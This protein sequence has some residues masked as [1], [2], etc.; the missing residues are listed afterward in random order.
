MTI[1]WETMITA[2]AKAATALAAARSHA[3][4]R[5]IAHVT[6]AREALITRLPG[7][8]MIYLAKEAEARAWIAAT[9]P[10]I[11]DY[12][13]LAAEAG[14]TAPDP[15]QLAQLWLNMA[16]LWRTTAADLEAA[17]LGTEAAIGAAATAA[18][19]ERAL[20]WMSAQPDL[21]PRNGGRNMA[22]GW[23]A[24]Q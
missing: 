22:G 4:A 16:A 9:D 2:E 7:Q 1:Q 11:A 13:L 18:E 14:L 6:A 5:L 19:I 20:E 15:G 12:P 10:D 21:Q 24:P 17:R 23:P 3:R 8:D